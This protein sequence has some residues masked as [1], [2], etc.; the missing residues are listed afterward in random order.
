MKSLTVRACMR[1][2]SIALKVAGA[3]LFASIMLE[4]ARPKRT[5]QKPRG[6]G[7]AVN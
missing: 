5:A 6:F 7:Q 4:E 3:A 2:A 1:V